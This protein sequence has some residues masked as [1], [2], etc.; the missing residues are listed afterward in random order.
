M[1]IPPTLRR[2]V[3]GLMGRGPAEP[4]DPYS[5]VRVT[6]RRGPPGRAAAVALEETEGERRSVYLGRTA[7]KDE[8]LME[9]CRKY[10]RIC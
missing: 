8:K 9:L 6:V 7:A 4:E 3:R 5:S 10:L 1:K 2:F